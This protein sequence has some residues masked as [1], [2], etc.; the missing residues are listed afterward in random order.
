MAQIETWLKTDLKQIVKVQELDGQLFT[1]DNQANLIGVI[2]TDKGAPVTLTGAVTGFAIRSDGETVVITGSIEENRAYIIL[3]ASAYVKAGPIHIVIKVGNTT[4]GACTSYIGPS[5]TDTIVDPGRVIPSLA[6]LLAQIENCRNATTAANTAAGNASTQASAAETAATNANTAAADARAAVAEA[7]EAAEAA[8][9]AAEAANDAADAAD[10]ATTA[11]NTAASSANSAA[12][13]ANTAASAANTAADA[14]DTAAANANTKAGLADAAATNANTKAGLADAAATDA[15]AAAAEAEAAAESIDDM[16][17]AANGLQPGSNPTVIISE[18]DGHKHILFG[19]PK[20]DKGKDFHIAKTFASIAAMMAYTGT[21]IEAYDFA[22]IDTGSVQDPDTGKLYCYEP[23]KNPKWRYIGDLSGAQ[24]IK[25]ETGTGISNIVLN[26]DYTLTIYTDDGSS[27][28]TVSIR[29]AKGDPGVKGDAG[30]NAYVH[31]RYSND[32]PTQDSDMGT[33][34][35]NW[36]GIYS[37]TSSTAPTSYLSYSWFKIKGETG[38]VENVYG[39]TVPMSE[40]DPTTVAAAIGTKLNSN[41]GSTNAGKF[42]KVGNDGGLVPDTVPDPTGKADKVQNATSGNFAGLDANGN[43]TDSGHKASDFLTQHQDISGKVDKNQGVAHAGKALGIN[44]QGYVEPVAFSG[45]DFTGATASTDGTHGYVPAPEAGQQDLYLK[46]SGEWSQAPGASIVTVEGTVT[47]VGGPY[48]GNFYD[49]RVTASMKALELE[50]EDPKI[51]GDVVSVACHDGYITV[52]CSD[53]SGESDIVVSMLK[54]AE[55]API[56]ITSTEFDILNSRKV[57]KNQGVANAGKAL[58][59]NAQ[60]YVEPVP[61]SGED[62]TGAT[63]STDGAHGYVVAPE[64]GDQDK[65]LKGDGTWGYPDAGTLTVVPFSI[66]AESWTLSN[67]VYSYTFLTEFVTLTSVEFVEYDASFK[68]ALR[69][70]INQVKAQGG[71]GVTFTTDIQPVATLSGEIRVFDRNDGK[72]A[73]V[74]RVSALPTIRDIPFTVAVSAWNLNQD[75]MYEAVFTTPFVSATSHD[76]VELD[77]SVENATDGIKATKAESDGSVIGMKFL[78]RRVPAGPISGTITPLDNDDG[79]VAVALQDTVM[80][81]ANGGTGANT[82]AGAQENLGIT[83]I[84]ANLGNVYSVPFNAGTYG[85]SNAKVTDNLM[86]Q[87][88][89]YLLILVL[90]AS[91]NGAAALGICNSTGVINERYCLSG[92]YATIITPY[93]VE[94]S[95]EIWGEYKASA[96]TTFTYPERGGLYAIQFK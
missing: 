40:Q 83:T 13:A 15:N 31:I 18:V 89:F 21:D 26:Q 35:D 52:T 61:F 2:V 63:A 58:G 47:N 17:V 46:G 3:P 30:D 29:G 5:T 88:G 54:V 36:M 53:V 25:G 93:F 76:F 9:E 45:E 82:L 41:Q 73:I 56:T 6:D 59:I 67:G 1:A 12:S 74:T 78:S 96:S 50:V 16:T 77:E 48:S 19:I 10:A 86:L 65:Y 42:M 80:P 84:K 94:S 79:K 20:G 60:G 71:G 81:I 33:T 34:P 85:S 55:V 32:Q 4:V 24:G 14:A 72:V 8:N 44:S 57:D 90:P 70:D 91:N 51:F 23:D 62:F 87:P 22:M 66:S 69:G 28:T 11:A 75:G 68:R 92:A 64:A 43:L 38:A 95:H 7:A 39:N 49:E 37:G 27:Y